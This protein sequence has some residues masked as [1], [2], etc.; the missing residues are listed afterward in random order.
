MR[1]S[2]IDNKSFIDCDTV[3]VEMATGIDLETVSVD[4]ER[5][6]AGQL[7]AMH[8]HALKTKSPLDAARYVKMK[9]RYLNYVHKRD[10]LGN[11]YE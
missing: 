9:Q 4:G 2:T 8:D 1:I 7:A 10:V 6:N 3:V 11:R 5:L